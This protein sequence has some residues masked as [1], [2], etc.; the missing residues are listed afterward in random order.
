MMGEEYPE[1]SATCETIKYWIN[2]AP[3]IEARVSLAIE[4][5][6]VTAEWDGALAYLVVCD[7]ADVQVLCVTYSKD[8]RNVGDTVLFGG[9][10]SRVGERKIMLD[11][12]LASLTHDK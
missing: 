7:E 5:K 12:C 6:L 1:V 11:P 10:Y 8:G 9:G 2:H 3:E 4:G